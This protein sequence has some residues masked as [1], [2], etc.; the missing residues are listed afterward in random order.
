MIYVYRANVNFQTVP[1]IIAE[2]RVIGIKPQD[3]VTEKKYLIDILF[4]ISSQ[5]FKRQFEFR[6]LYDFDFP[7]FAQVKNRRPALT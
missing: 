4:T 6:H 3:L 7:E 1:N 5:F 2:G